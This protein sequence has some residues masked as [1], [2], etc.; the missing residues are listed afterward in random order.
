M[1]TDR[2]EFYGPH[3]SQHV[4]WQ[5][6]G[7]KGRSHTRC[8]LL[9]CASCSHTRAS[10]TKQYRT[11]MRYSREGNRRSGVARASRH[12]RSSRSGE[13]GYKLLYS[14]YLL[15]FELTDRLEWF[16]HPRA[17]SRSNHMQLCGS[18]QRR[19]MN[20]ALKLL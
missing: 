8:A 12:R 18:N 2:N 17:G 4:A 16:M 3:C 20:I 14:V 1:N 10:V 6:T 15:T 5:Y 9:R 7:V 19:E 11:V 13:A